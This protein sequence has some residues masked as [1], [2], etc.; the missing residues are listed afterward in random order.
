M[1]FEFGKDILKL[2]N[3]YIFLIRLQ[4]IFAEEKSK[5]GTKKLKTT[6]N[7]LNE[8]ETYKKAQRYKRQD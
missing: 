1:A 6:D 5:Q 2:E 8:I 3:R 7:Q 4:K